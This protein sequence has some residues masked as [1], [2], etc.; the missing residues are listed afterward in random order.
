MFLND[1]YFPF[2]RKPRST[3]DKKSKHFKKGLNNEENKKTNKGNGKK[4]PKKTKKKSPESVMNFQRGGSFEDYHILSSKSRHNHHYLHH[5]TRQFPYTRLIEEEESNLPFDDPSILFMSMKSP[6]APARSKWFR[7]PESG[8]LEFQPA[9][10]RPCSPANSTGSKDSDLA[11]S[12]DSCSSDDSES[13][14]W[15][16]SPSAWR[17]DLNLSRFETTYRCPDPSFQEKVMDHRLE[18]YKAIFTDIFDFTVYEEESPPSR[19]SSADSDSCI[20]LGPSVNDLLLNEDDL[21][22]PADLFHTDKMYSSFT[23][24]WDHHQNGVYSSPLDNAFDTFSPSYLENYISREHSEYCTGQLVYSLFRSASDETINCSC[25]EEEEEDSEDSPSQEEESKVVSCFSS[26]DNLNLQLQKYSQV[27]VKESNLQLE[28]LRS[29]LSVSN[30]NKITL[31]KGYHL[32]PLMDNSN[33]MLYFQNDI[34]TSVFLMSLHNGCI[35]GLSVTLTSKQLNC[36]LSMGKVVNTAPKQL[37]IRKFKSPKKVKHRDKLKSPVDQTVT[38]TPPAPPSS[39][40]KLTPPPPIEKE[41]KS[42]NPHNLSNPSTKKAK[43]SSKKGSKCPEKANSNLLPSRRNHCNKKISKNN[44]KSTSENSRK[45]TQN[46]NNNSNRNKPS[47][48]PNSQQEKGAEHQSSGFM[49]W[50]MDNSLFKVSIWS[51][52]SNPSPST[53]SDN[54]H[55]KEQTSSSSTNTSAVSKSFQPFSRF[56][57]FSYLSHILGAFEFHLRRTTNVKRSLT[58]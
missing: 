16:P 5:K 2:F 21:P 39:Q 8:L 53:T 34:F 24:H 25:Q 1:I 17:D 43:R 14:L 56:V 40:Q 51:S 58:F 27:P 35:N 6:D 19:S 33:Y 49:K 31:D 28:K 32:P 23:D 46:S 52:W 10:K 37:A 26:D 50:V 13:W 9:Y 18:S 29:L 15:C 41:A 12:D 54:L 7:N 44:N 42:N 48:S 36:S 20:G 55:R 4:K 38:P 22:N 30:A 3:K 47:S 11:S 57:C 45:T